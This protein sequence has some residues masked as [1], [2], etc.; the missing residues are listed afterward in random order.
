MATTTFFWVLAAF[1]FL[2]LSVEIVLDVINW[3]H[4]LKH[5]HEIPELFKS[6]ISEETYLKSINYTK[7]K[8][9]FHIIQLLYQACFAWLLILSGAFFKID[10]WTKSIF[11]HDFIQAILYPFTVG[12]LFYI[13][14]LPLAV[15]QQFLL[16]AR[17]GFN[18]M[19][20]STF[21]SDQIKALIL[22]CALGL[23]IVTLI[24]WLIDIAGPF[25]W[26]W[27][28]IAIMAFQL[29]T[30][31]LFPVLLAPIFYKFSP[32]PEGE[33]KNRLTML[34]ETLR[35]KM[36]G[37]FTIDGSKRSTHSNAFFA[38][39]G[40]ARRIVLFDTLV[41]N[42]T[43]DEITSVIAHEMGHN[44]KKHIQR[45]LVLSGLTMMAGF[46]VLSFCLQWP[47]FY[48]T[49]GVIN[50]SIHIGV[51]LFVLFS[52]VFTF[53]L[54][55]LFHALSRKHE[56]EADA[57]SVQTLNDKQ[58]M[59]SSLM[60]LSKDNLVNLTPHPWYSFFHYTH[61]TTLERVMAIK[62]LNLK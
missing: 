45:S 47:E 16:E 36:A 3:R 29:L 31:A 57:F 17:F 26:I 21:I 46:W 59:I 34:A 58:H 6:S 62:Q 37:I 40:R 7:S 25:W 1:Y 33:L 55:P 22:S 49:F 32:L 12:I 54:N 9:K 11:T 44:I 56:Y 41:N 24:F 61:P 53:P 42:L 20:A 48:Q 18:K 38:G 52:S 15:Y 10:L 5:R 27:G 35:F 28:F 39:M 51:V 4:V 23:P 14:N 2:Y 43:T 13:A 60:K 30:A 19:A 8:I 50:P